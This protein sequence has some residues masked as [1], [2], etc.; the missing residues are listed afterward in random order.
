MQCTKH[1]SRKEYACPR[2]GLSTHFKNN[3]IEHLKRKKPCA[4]RLAD[5]DTVAILKQFEDEYAAKRFECEHCHKRFSHHPAMYA[6]K[7]TCVCRKQGDASK[8]KEG[9]GNTSNLT[10]IGVNSGAV[11]TTSV[12]G[13]NNNV[14]ITQIV[15]INPIEYINTSFINHSMYNKLVELVKRP[16][17]V[18]VAIMRLAEMLFFNI[19]HPE[20]MCVYI[21]NK[22][23][24]NAL[25]W[26]GS[27]W[28]YDTMDSAV[29]QIRNKA[30]IMII[31]H[32]N[33]NAYKFHLFTQQEFNAY[34]NRVN[35]EEPTVFKNAD[36]KIEMGLLTNS[37]KVKDYIKGKKVYSDSNL[38]DNES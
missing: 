26:D 16:G 12:S 28:K 31:G 36:K 17:Q 3:F 1:M 20:N 29:R 8:A 22:K 13:E 32:Y 6:H 37:N 11:A 5:A 7:K 14:N 9:T 23:L 4:P 34:K 15:H 35:I 38:Y 18:D 2:C 19:A 10:S 25:L 21:P 24:K 27:S 30:Y 33:D